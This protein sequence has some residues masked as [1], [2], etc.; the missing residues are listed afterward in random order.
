MCETAN[1]I[2]MCQLQYIIVPVKLMMI[3]EFNLMFAF[4]NLLF[5][6]F[7]TFYVFFSTQLQLLDV[8]CV[9]E[10]AKYYGLSDLAM[11]QMIKEVELDKLIVFYHVATNFHRC[12]CSH[13]NT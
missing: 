4:I 5:F 10:M 9:S 3:L 7:Q 8:D 6:P 12:K 11:F 2:I 1:F 13:L